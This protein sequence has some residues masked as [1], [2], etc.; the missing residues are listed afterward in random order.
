M[1]RREQ[2]S[3]EYDD[4]LSQLPITDRLYLQSLVIR[5]LLARKLEGL[6]PFAPSTGPLR[7]TALHTVSLTA[8]LLTWPPTDALSIVQLWALSLLA[9]YALNE[10][11][12]GH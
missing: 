3:R 1:S 10:L 12:P 4:I 2:R 11:L 7:I 9:T 6:S 8:V 5:K